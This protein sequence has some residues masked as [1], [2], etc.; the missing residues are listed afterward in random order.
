MRKPVKRLL[1]TAGAAGAVAFINHMIFTAADINPRT[2]FESQTYKWRHGR[3]RYVTA[4]KGE[5]VLM[6]HDIGMGS[7]LLEW[8]EQL[9]LLSKSYRVYGI[10]LLGFGASAKPNISYSAY[11]YASLLNDFIRDVVGSP[12]NLVASSGSAAIAIASCSLS[13]ELYNKL[14]LVSPTGAGTAD[15]PIT[16]GSLMLRSLIGLPVVGTAIYNIISSR[17][18]QRCFLKRNHIFVPDMAD[19]L[20]YSAHAGGVGNKYPIAAYLGKLLNVKLS[21]MAGTVDVPIHVCWGMQNTSNP[22]SNF[23]ALRSM[24]DDIGLTVFKNSG[25]MPHKSQPKKFY[26]LCKGFFAG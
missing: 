19:K 3:I 6:V 12:V 13:P 4:G 22:F 14:L 17:V 20:Y 11:L 18:Y 8:E 23:A 24:N 2:R 16:F 1:L 10:D 5:P 15:P 21:V 7:S 25:L 9:Y 26:R